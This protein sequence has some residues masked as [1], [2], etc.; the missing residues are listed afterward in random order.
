MRQ[1]FDRETDAFRAA[2]AGKTDHVDY[3]LVR[4]PDGSVDVLTGEDIPPQ[5]VP[6]VVTPRQIR[7]ALTQLGLRQTVEQA[8]AAGSQDLK[9][10]WEY[11]LDIERDHPL[12][13]AMAQQ[14][15]IT[16][17]QVDGL[18]QLAASL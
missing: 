2:I 15:G 5:P 12:I 7:L 16:G 1:E 11:A 4:Y 9:D 8:V 13:E 6:E 17:E 18:F 3:E 10:W 14:L